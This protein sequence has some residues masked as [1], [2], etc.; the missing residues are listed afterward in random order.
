MRKIVFYTLLMSFVAGLM[1]FSKKIEG[2]NRHVFTQGESVTYRLHYGFIT[3]GEATINVDPQLYKI[4]NKIC[5][6][7]GVYGKSTGMFAKAMY[8][9]D[10]WLSYVD[11][12]TLL[13]ELGYR[14]IKESKYRLWET[15]YFDQKDDS[16]K[17][18]SQKKKKSNPKKTKYYASPKEVHD[19]V[20][21]YFFLRNIDY[22]KMKKGDRKR[23]NA[24]LEDTNYKFEVVYKGKEVVKTKLGKINAI[25]LTPDM[26][27]NDLF[28]GDESIT[29]WLSDDGNR[30]PLK[31]EAKL[32]VGAVEM[33]I[34]SHKNLK[35][36]L[37]YAK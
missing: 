37:N 8:I 4:D 33:D 16:V 27:E 22:N 23:I 9:D 3:A 20:S 28:E 10:R 34:E 32:F 15:T 2:E 5:Y 24:F 31:V 35:H 29:I 12:T 7:L 6:K 21:G 36:K 19:M 18:V 14:E 1:S 17:I 30:V 13:P 25:K 11:T 26:P